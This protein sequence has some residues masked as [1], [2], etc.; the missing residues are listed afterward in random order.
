MPGPTNT[1]LIEGT[2]SELAEEFAQY[3]DALS[4]A[5]E[6]AGVQAEIADPLNI[7][8]EA[9][10]GEEAVE[11]STI[12]PQKDEVLKKLVTKASILNSAPE[13]EFTPA[14]NLLISLSLQSPIY[15]QF[16]A[17]IC[18]YLSEQPV[19]SSA[20]YGASLALQSLT[21]V[22]NVLPPTSEARY[23]V[24]LAILKVIKATSSSQAFEALIPQLE[25]NIPEWLA[26]WQLD[27]E[28]A[29]SLYTAVAD[30]A[31][32]SGNDDLSYA[33]LMKALETIPPESA[34]DGEAQELAKRTL[35][36]ALTNPSVTDFTA[37][38]A[39]DAI[40]AIRRADSNLFDLLEIF[41]S[42]DYSSYIDFLETNELS[43][44]GIQEESG[45]VLSTKIRLL[46]LAS[47]A[48]T[49]QTRSVSYSTIASALQVPSEDVE[50]WVIDTI[51]AGLVEGKLSQ[52]K[53]EFLVQRATYRVF[54]EK[55]W[56]EIQ[57]RLLVWRRS[58]ESVLSVVK[59]E[60]ERFLREGPTHADAGV[61][62]W[63]DGGDNQRGHYGGDRQRRQGGGGGGGRRGGGGQYREHR[64]QREQQG[65]REV[66]AVGG[67]D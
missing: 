55:Q 29:R 53:Q 22:F 13:R 41:S 65:P 66:E 46:T 40:Q 33:Y 47:I 16:F 5:E 39:N 14:Y 42:D 2:F 23:H 4:K 27:D 49:S 15:E 20:V 56:T 31:A 21:T 1:L 35:R 7:I 24:F 3:L 10:Q 43:S 28:D 25:T 30:V 32:V 38:T 11:A 50:M 62:G 54:G 34:A 48:A 57:G 59:A 9:E 12:Q 36:L 60:R 67:G 58:L 26:A 8:R 37:L 18:Q 19:T 51:R 6:G 45:D 61:N 64:E 52:L 44:L 17:R 63:G